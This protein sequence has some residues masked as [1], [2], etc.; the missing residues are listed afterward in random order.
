MRTMIKMEVTVRKNTV[1]FNTITN[2]ITNMGLIY[3]ALW[4]W[5]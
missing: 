3:K 1:E 4:I 5:V 2:G